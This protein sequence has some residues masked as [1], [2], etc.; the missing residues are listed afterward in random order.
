MWLSATTTRRSP[1]AR[2]RALERLVAVAA[3]VF[4]IGTQYPAALSAAK[5]RA[6]RAPEALAWPVGLAQLERSRPL[7]EP[8]RPE[9]P[10]CESRSSPSEPRSS[11]L[12]HAQSAIQ[13]IA[14]GTRVSLRIRIE[15]YLSCLAYRRTGLQH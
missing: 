3:A 5:Q 10:R 9:A 1:V 8:T 12:S 15:T 7:D 6:P 2:F 14:T 11:Q 13:T 4:Q